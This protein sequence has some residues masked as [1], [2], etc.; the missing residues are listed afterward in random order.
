MDPL[1]FLSRHPLLI[2]GNNDT[3]K[4]LK[5]AIEME[6]A[7]VLD[8]IKEETQK[9]GVLQKLSQTIK[10]DDW[11]VKKRD[12]DLAPFYP[13]KDEIYE[14]QGLIFRMER[15]ILQ[16][17]LQQ[18]II[19][20]AHKLGHLGTTK[21]KQMLRA[22][23]WFPNMN[24]MIDQ[25]IGHCYDCQV[26][27]KNHREEPIKPSV[28]PEE[29]WEQIAID[30]GGPYPDGHYNLVVIDQR[31]RYREVEV[32]PS[33]A[34]NPTKEKLKRMFAH[35]GI[36]RRVYSDNGPPFNSKEFSDFAE[37]GFKHHRVTPLHPRANGQV[38]RFMQLLNKTEQ[39][40]HLQGQ[41]G[42][43]RN[44]AV[45]DM[46]MAYR[47]TPHPAT[48]ITPYQAMANRPIRTK[49]DHTMPEKERSRQDELI[50]ERDRKDKEKMKQ[51]G[52]N[53]KE[54]NFILRDYVLLRQ[55]KSNKWSTPYEPI[56]YTVINI[57]G[58]TIT[59]R[60]I[61]DGREICGD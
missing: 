36:P 32:V 8:R 17:S 60:R 52:A 57:S 4:I 47:D 2:I 19:K 10:R 13:I 38:E 50:D 5:T 48:G 21:T 55:K 18:K 16:S 42:L 37:E 20:T 61:T 23:Y 7:V 51:E 15:I 6:H 59:A 58:S 43:D 24:A 3:E 33:T 39:I 40:A 25:M 56:F 1:D 28:I 26:T 45:E 44:I 41:T 34:F 11:N 49:L 14:A 27:T 9:D 35:H 53:I 30:F 31:T 12:V 54:H 46:L 29:P 22:K